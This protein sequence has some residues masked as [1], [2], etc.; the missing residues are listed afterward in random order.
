[1]SVEKMI[2]ESMDKDPMT[3]KES[4]QEELR[5]RIALALEAKM[6]KESDCDDE[7]DEDE[8]DLDEGELSDKDWEA[9]RRKPGQSLSKSKPKKM[10]R[11]NNGKM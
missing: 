9:I 8:D 10:K 7:D 5:S 2:K 4:I 11:I 1:M 6:N 3:L